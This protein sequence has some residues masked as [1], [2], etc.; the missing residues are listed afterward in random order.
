LSGAAIAAPLKTVQADLATG[1]R[2]P[3][4]APPKPNKV[5]PPKPVQADTQLINRN[6]C[7]GLDNAS[8]D[9]RIGG[10]TAVIQ[11]GQDTPAT[12]AAIFVNRAFAYRTKG[13]NNRAIQDFDQ[14]IKLVP[15]YP[16]AFNGRGIAWHAL[17]NYDRAIADFNE[18][19]RLSPMFSNALTNRG[20]S[21]WEKGSRDNAMADYDQATRIDPV[22]SFAFLSRGR[23]YR[24]AGDYDHAIE[25][26]DQMIRLQRTNAAAWNERCYTQLVA[27]AAPSNAL[28]DCSESL[29]INPN[30]GPALDNR[31]LALLKLNE[32]DRA[33]AD[34]DAALRL[35][36][37]SAGSLYGRGL[38]KLKKGDIEGGNA[39]IAAAKAIRPDVAKDFARHG[40]T[41]AGD[42]AGASPRT[43]IGG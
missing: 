27:D 8:A 35:A 31:G 4:A 37:R 16:A 10:C 6:Q 33:I 2:L 34:Y 38:A 12:L 25:D 41:V 29:K 1:M 9:L 7:A 17:R 3:A 26:F 40:L 13:D 30:S 18:A 42:T 21:Y 19:I 11:S 5:E 22:N 28:A 39:D 20:N 24:V 14:A 36:P 32:P 43:P 23:A 15:N